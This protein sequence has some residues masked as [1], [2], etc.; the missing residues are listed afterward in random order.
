MLEK[1]KLEYADDAIL[2]L[3][4]LKQINIL[5]VGTCINDVGLSWLLVVLFFPGCG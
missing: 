3:N 4:M 2:Y 1:L 5:K